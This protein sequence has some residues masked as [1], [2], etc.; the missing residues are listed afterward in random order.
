VTAPAVD[1]PGTDAPGTRR[2][3]ALPASPNL[4]A[5]YARAGL[6]S[7]RAAVGGPL[8]RALGGRGGASLG[9]ALPAV[10]H[11]VHGIRPDPGAL[12]AY[13]HLLGEPAGDVL[14]A[15][16][17]HVLAF[18]VAIALIVRPDF[19]MPPLGIVHLANR[20]EQRSPLRVG[21]ELDVRAWAR[22]L[23]PHRKGAQ[24]ELVTEVRRA[25]SSP[26]A[27]P[28]WRGV[29]T[30]LAPG[31]RVP[32]ADP[33]QPARAEFAAP[34]PTGRWALD[35]GTGRRYAAVSGDA[36]PI[37]LTPLTARALGFPRAIAHGMY[38]AA[39][40]LADVGAR[41]GDAYT[42]DVEFAAPVLLPSSPAVRVGP[43]ADEDGWSVVVWDAKR[44]KLHLTAEVRPL[45]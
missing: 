14:P 1:A 35:A 5:L 30:Y 10:E 44:G 21:D 11:R 16:Y 22:D 23:R 18:P 6:A 7:G 15:G 32:G 45:G 3:V 29:S 43:G 31:V 37:H 34:V 28:E 19:P 41:R 36:N 20:V 38:T 33:A 40:A 42:W 26:D 9:P 8:R 2:V 27:A 17:V 12:T 13:Q 25:G 39:R 24:V 4:G